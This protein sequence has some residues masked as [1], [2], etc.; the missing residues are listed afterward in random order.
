[1]PALAPHCRTRLS[2]RLRC[3]RVPALLCAAL[4][5]GFLAAAS[6]AG[7]PLRVVAAESVYG[8]IARQ[9]GGDDVMVS[10]VLSQPAQDPHAFEANTA[11]ARKIA[12]A[13]VV[14]YN[15]A[16]YD[17]WMARLLAASR[18]RSRTAIEVAAM[19]QRPAGA[20][21]HLWYD[22]SAM[23]ALAAELAKTYSQLDAAHAQRYADRLAAFES[24]LTP[25]R[26]TIDRMRSRYA[27]TPVTATEPVFGY[28]AEALQLSMHNERF[29]LAVMNGVEPPATAVAM[30][31]QDL[32]SHAVKALLYNVQTGEALCERMRSIATEVGIPVVPVTETKPPAER[33]QDWMLSQLQRLDRAL[34]GR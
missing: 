21:P 1:M 12:D 6:A 20:N 4:A 29:Q 11:T 13:E 10:S 19:M 7:A 23:Q 30:F 28:M 17:P 24:A 32:R 34:A 14:I 33:Y 26:Q 9:I 18:S 5:A 27:G 31:E 3:T 25:L 2:F 8:D 22:V 15:G 16:G